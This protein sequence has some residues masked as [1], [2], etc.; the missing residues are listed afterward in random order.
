MDD[1][2]A[3]EEQA[4]DEQSCSEQPGDDHHISGNEQPHDEQPGDEESTSF[5]KLADSTS[6]SSDVIYTHTS[7]VEDDV[8]KKFWDRLAG[9]Y[10]NL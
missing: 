9:I 10:K 5:I 7:T 8:T 2:K 3:G 6:G 1:D 4:V